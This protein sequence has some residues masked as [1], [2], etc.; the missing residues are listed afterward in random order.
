MGFWTK[1]RYDTIFYMGLEAR[2]ETGTRKAESSMDQRSIMAEQQAAFGFQSD[3]ITGTQ[4][5]TRALLA[6][7]DRSGLLFSSAP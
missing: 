6:L 5:H 3:P 4:E 7:P 1:R 2:H